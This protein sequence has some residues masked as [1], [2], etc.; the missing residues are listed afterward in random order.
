VFFTTRC[1]IRLRAE[2]AIRIKKLCACRLDKFDSI[3]HFI[4]CAILTFIR[5]EE[6]EVKQNIAQQKQL[7][8]KK[9]KR[10]TRSAIKTVP[11]SS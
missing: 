8:C 3:S 7:K 1:I 5:R 4:R 6:D 2:D 10:I 9:P 11:E